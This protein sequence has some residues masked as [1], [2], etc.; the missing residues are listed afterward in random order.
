MICLPIPGR[1]SWLTCQEPAQGGGLPQRPRL[2][3]G[4]KSI[5]LRHILLA[6]HLEFQQT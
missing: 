3:I 1:C 4:G 6:N 5:P 2:G